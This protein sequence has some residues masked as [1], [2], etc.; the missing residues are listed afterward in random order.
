ML[1]GDT[2]QSVHVPIHGFDIHIENSKKI[3]DKSIIMK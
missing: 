3:S 2:H 1:F